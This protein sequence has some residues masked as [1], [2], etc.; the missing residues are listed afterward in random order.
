ML[1]YLGFPTIVLSGRRAWRLEDRIQ[2]RL[3]RRTTTLSHV[4]QNSE[5]HNSGIVAIAALVDTAVA[6]R[7]RVM[8]A[9]VRPSVVVAQSKHTSV[10]VVATHL[11]CMN[12]M[13]AYTTLQK[14]HLVTD[15]CR[16]ARNDVT[17]CK[18]SSW[19]RHYDVIVDC[20]TPAKNHAT[21]LVETASH[22][23]VRRILL[24]T[25]PTVS[26]AVGQ[27]NSSKIVGQDFKKCI[28]KKYFF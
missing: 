19:I 20:R 3:S 18:P 17:T 2:L 21:W 26:W 7:N 6:R 5:R 13:H 1:F 16:Y 15:L 28:I 23:L 27:S 10:C 14:F 12:I 9:R 22:G 11:T 4:S 25:G 8:H 24:D